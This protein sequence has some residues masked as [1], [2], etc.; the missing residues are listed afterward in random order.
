VGADRIADIQFPGVDPDVRIILYE[1]CGEFV[2]K[3]RIRMRVADE[4][5]QW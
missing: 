5:W 1:M 4:N 3:L 2:G